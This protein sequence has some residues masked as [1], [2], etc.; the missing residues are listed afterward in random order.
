MYREPESSSL[1][2]F[3]KGHIARRL[4][5]AI[6]LFSSFITLSTTSYQLY[7]DYRL[8][9]QAIHG[10]FDL[11]Q[12]S[13]I[14]SLSR[15]VW[16]YDSR[17]IE[18][19]LDGLSKL[20]DIE[21]LEIQAGEKYRWTSG[22]P[23]STH[24]ITRLFPL[25]F[26]HKDQTFS[27]GTLKATVSLD[28]VY[29][30]LI[31]KTLTILVTN[32]I[33]AFLV[34]GFILLIFHLLVTRHLVELAGDVGKIDVRRPPKRIELGRKKRSAKPDEIDQVVD[35]LNQ[36]QAE[37]HRSY[38]TLKSSEDELNRIFSMSIDMICIADLRTATF[39]KVNP[40]FTDTLGYSAE[41]LLS[42]SFMRFVH[43]DDVESTQRVIDEQLKK[44]RKVISF[45]NR[46]LC[47]DGA[48]RWLRWVS[49]P[50]PEK[51][52][53]YAVAS[54]ITDIKL[55]ISELEESH[56]RFLTVLDSIEATI[57]ATDMETYEVVFMNKHM[58]ESFGRDMTGEIC[59]K[60]FRK[61][62]GPCPHCTSDN[63]VDENG[64]PTGVLV[65]QDHNPVTGRWCLNY[66][67]AIEWIDGR[68]VRIQIAT[69]VTELKKMEEQLRRA[70]KMEAI[71]TLAGG[72]AH[73]FNN[74]LSII[75]GNTELAMG[76]LPDGSEAREHLEEAKAACLRARDLVSQMLLFARKTEHTPARISVEP[77]ARESMK[78]LRATIPSTVEVRAD[79]Q[80]GLPPVMADSSQIQQIIM[81][82]CT[83][84]GQSMEEEGGVLNVRLDTVSLDAPLDT[85]S[86]RIPN[87]RYI[88]MR[89]QD[90]GPGI[91]PENLDRIF[92]P[93]FTTKGVGEG[94]GLGLAVVHGIVQ[95]RRGGITV[96]SEKGKGTAFTVY[97][98]AAERTPVEEA[99]A[100]TPGLPG[101]TERILFVDDEPMIAKL[102]RRMLERG[103]YEVTIQA[104][105]VD[106][107]DCFRQ[108]PER[109]DLV[110]TAVSYTHLTLPT[111]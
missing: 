24:I 42:T 80:E 71:G 89:V 82:L 60:A 99:P 43:P 65:W 97:L 47:K 56:R 92:E 8:D 62:S 86:G 55:F 13:Y 20:P 2:V 111:N 46:Y 35:A 54:D 10:Y 74:I 104:N 36:I 100:E 107:L 102:G 110:I 49:H 31:H 21:F 77:I 34:S 30:R 16:M 69:D 64:N 103:G 3:T 50:L 59:W 85:L 98:P 32:G 18:A 15:S 6:V 72:I 63:L 28:N 70:Q 39:L 5:V 76:S 73:D 58:I 67:R 101:G 17:Q 48:V 83:N 96:E 29:D 9:L 105:G 109:F 106:A 75:V 26:R 84:A 41:E 25:T 78:M 87:G 12:G 108:D 90:T 94:T 11:I 57:Y 81:N 1:S 66:D 27:I 51:G 19:Q 14:E 88:R 45:E 40:A 91:P 33:R 79:L 53:T 7:R 68:L 52:I 93:F 95:D 37:L 4:V 22:S 61:E 38:Q 23:R 44:G